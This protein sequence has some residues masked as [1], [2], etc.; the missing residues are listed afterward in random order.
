MLAE[1]VAYFIN[2][3]AYSFFYTLRQHQASGH[4]EKRD[5][6]FVELPVQNLHCTC[7]LD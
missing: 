2:E 6:K 7:M 1:M 3:V 5:Y 4:V